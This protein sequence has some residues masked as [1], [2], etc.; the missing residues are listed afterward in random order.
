M[1]SP[2]L[3]EKGRMHLQVWAGILLYPLF[4]VHVAPNLLVA[5]TRGGEMRGLQEGN[6]GRDSLNLPQA[7][8][9]LSAWDPL[10]TQ[11]ALR[12]ADSICS[13]RLGRGG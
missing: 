7:T 5:L 1:A 10:C 11:A 8:D 12:S 3:G 13:A 6:F 4:P 9:K 2:L